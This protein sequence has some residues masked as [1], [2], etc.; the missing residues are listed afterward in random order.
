M[1]PTSSTPDDQDTKDSSIIKVKQGTMAPQNQIIVEIEESG[2]G[3]NTGLDIDAADGTYFDLNNYLI[4]SR[5][6]SLL[7]FIGYKRRGFA[8]K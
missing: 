5:Y 3:G 6:T 2:A 7:C 1:I 8:C 4:L